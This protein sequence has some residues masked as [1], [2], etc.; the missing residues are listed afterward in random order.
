MTDD[1]PALPAKAT[2]SWEGEQGLKVNQEV[3]LVVVMKH[4]T[5]K[6]AEG[7]KPQVKGVKKKKSMKKARE[8]TKTAVNQTMKLQ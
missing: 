7:V 3:S 1:V 4:G 8:R 5:P 6:G 2:S